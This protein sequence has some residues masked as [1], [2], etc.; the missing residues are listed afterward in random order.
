[1]RRA[2]GRIKS[3]T[4]AAPYICTDKKTG[5]MVQSNADFSYLDAY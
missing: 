5:N 1:M 3:Q 2:D 4:T